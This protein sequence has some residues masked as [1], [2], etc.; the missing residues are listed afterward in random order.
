MSASKDNVPRPEQSTNASEKVPRLAFARRVVINAVA[1]VFAFLS[2]CEALQRLQR[3]RERKSMRPTHE[4]VR[5]WWQSF[6]VGARE[7]VVMY[8]API[9]WIFRACK[10]RGRQRGRSRIP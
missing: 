7:G 1:P 3:R 9:T 2:Y 6:G 8:F 5:G 10:R 4:S